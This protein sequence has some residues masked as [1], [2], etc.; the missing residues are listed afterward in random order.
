MAEWS[1]ANDSKSFEGKPSVGSNPTLSVFREKRGFP[2]TPLT[3]QDRLRPVAL[4]WVFLAL[5]DK[6]VRALPQ[7]SQRYRISDGAGLLLEVD[8]AGGTYW[9]WRHRFPPTKDGRRQDLRIGPYPRISLKAARDIRD[10]QKSLL[11]EDGI[12]PCDAKKRPRWGRHAQLTFEAVALDWNAQQGHPQ[13][14][15]P[16]STPARCGKNGSPKFPSLYLRSE[17]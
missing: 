11:Y 7:R 3:S 14:A 17:F 5:T 9:L 1:K 6:E 13:H 16:V 8:P 15:P 2:A 10:E 4:Q 12:N